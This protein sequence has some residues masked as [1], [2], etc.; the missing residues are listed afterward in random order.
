MQHSNTIGRGANS[1]R[2][3]AGYTLLELLVVLA[4]IGILAAMAAPNIRD[5]LVRN[6][7]ESAMLDLMSAINRA[8]SQAVVQSKTATLCRS[9][10]QASC[11]GT[12]G[13]D[14][15][16]GWIIFTDTGVAGTLDGTDELVQVQSSQD[17]E[18]VITLLDSLNMPFDEDFLQFNKEGFLSNSTT[19][20]YFKLCDSQ[21]DATYARA[22]WL[23]NSGRPAQSLDV[24][25]DG[26]HD[27]MAGDPLACP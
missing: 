26:I 6:A 5:T 8:R 14:W 15:A 24:D 13:A 16:A 27:D 21:N 23:S 7:R 17:N 11:A 20:A 12:S 4:I 25:D 18:L 2:Q 3:S 10:N 22:V 9:T 19:G 1:S